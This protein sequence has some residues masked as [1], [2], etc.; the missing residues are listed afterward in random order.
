MGTARS[1]SS[2]R[3]SLLITHLGTHGFSSDRHPAAASLQ[4]LKRKGRGGDG[5]PAWVSVPHGSSHLPR[6]HRNLGTRGPPPHRFPTYVQDHPRLVTGVS[7]QQLLKRQ[8][9]REQVWDEAPAVHIHLNLP[10]AEFLI[11]RES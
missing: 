6:Q 8:N 9:L 2:R 1:L 11:N 4:D 10:W 7:S 3:P 5:P